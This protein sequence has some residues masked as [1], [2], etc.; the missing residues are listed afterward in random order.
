[1]GGFIAQDFYRR[2]PQRVLSLVLADT[3]NA[4]ERPNNDE[5]LKRREAPLLAGLTPRDIAPKLAPTL[6]SPSASRAALDE[7]TASIAALH[8]D[9]YLK[10]LRVT[11]TIGDL[12][13]YRDRRCFVDLEAVRVPTLVLG[14]SDDRVTPP[15]LSRSIAAA[16][17]GAELHMIDGAGHLSNIEMPA[18]FNAHLLRFLRS[19][20]ATA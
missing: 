3:R 2:N 8:K 18:Q 4:F 9:S 20:A 13:G 12:P 1:M 7:I 17:P 19:V 5:F 14:G 10:T 11:T 6:A 16:I 15:P